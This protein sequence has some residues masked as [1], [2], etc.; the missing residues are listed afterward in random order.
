VLLPS[1]IGAYI[2]IFCEQAFWDATGRLWKE[3]TLNAKYAGVFVSTSAPG[4]GQEAT[5]ISF[6]ST[7][8]HHGII[9]VPFGYATGFDKLKSVNEVHG[10]KSNGLSS[11]QQ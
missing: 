1:F 7:L 6:L 5:V 10:G 9:Y 11:F 2:H 8:A 3:G 4:G